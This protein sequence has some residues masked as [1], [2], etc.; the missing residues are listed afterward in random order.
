MPHSGPPGIRILLGSLTILVTLAVPA[1]GAIEGSPHDLISQGYDVVRVSASQER[2]TRCHLP[3][4]PTLQSFLPDVPPVLAPVFGVSSLACFSC[5]DGTTIVSPDVDASRTA[6][7]PASHGNDLKGYEGLRSEAVGLP[8]LGGRRMECVTCH[9]PHDN[10]H[11]PFLR[12]DLH[13]LCL[14]CHS[15]LAEYGR[16]KEN[17]TGS[18]ILEI[19]PALPSRPAVP[20]NVAPGTTTLP[21]K[22]APGSAALPPRG[23]SGTTRIEVPLKVAEAF[24]T[25]FPTAYPLEKGKGNGGWH[26]NLG[27]HLMKGAVGGVDCS[28][29]HMV[30]GDGGP[31]PPKLLTVA[32]GNDTANRFCEGCHAG[33]RGDGA[34]S[35][36]LPNPGGTIAGRTYHPADDDVSNGEGRIVEVTVPEG[37]P[38]GG[39]DPPRLLCTTCHVA[40]GA[41]VA[42]PLLRPTDGNTVLHG[43]SVATPLLQPTA[44]NPGFCEA[45]HTT[46]PEHHHP[47][48]G[49]GACEPN[50]NPVGETDPQGMRCVRCHQAHNAGLGAADENLHR[51]LLNWTVATTC[52]ECHPADNPTCSPRPETRASH[53]LGDPLAAYG[54]RAPP[55]YRD[56]WPESGLRS[57]FDDP[58]ARVVT[59]FS[60]HSFEKGALVSGDAGLSQHL[61][62]RSGNTLEWSPGGE[63]AYLCIG[64]HSLE[65]ATGDTKGHTH[66]MM[67][68]DV[69]KLPRPANSPVTTTPS[70]HVNCDSCHKPH[71]AAT[72]GGVYILEVVGGKNTDP[73]A[74]QPQIDFTS[75]CLSCHDK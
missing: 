43:A 57:S 26:W 36:A 22:V 14:A 39:G 5:H 66:K 32:P 37:W 40:H 70:G 53:F 69:S 65:P 55:L 41:A 15:R 2:C 23:P 49:K 42:T 63:S 6:F 3:T 60:C 1:R 11:R 28:T 52:V 24:R 73:K 7:H 51:P 31:P 54:D 67:D 38:L 75:L 35:T 19:D 21:L 48:T 33:Q 4:V 59:C 71:G 25:A 47:L 62:A 10:G 34:R 45:C 61:V 13:E 17:R 29:C 72:P 46:L 64:C 50:V 68:A 12:A 58:E 20:L 27:G 16:G 56:P 18:H 9:D 44:T 8:Y 74:I 30:H